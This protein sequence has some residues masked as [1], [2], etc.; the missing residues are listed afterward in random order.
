[1]AILFDNEARTY[2]ALLVV[3]YGGPEA[4]EEVMPFLDRVLAGRPVPEARKLEVA[5]HYLH[6]G[7]VSPIQQQT[8]D[9]IAALDADLRGAGLGLPIYWGNRNWH[10]LL[11]DTFHR[12][13]K[14][15]VRRALAF[16]TSAYSCWSGCRQYREDLARAVD[17]SGG[18]GISVDKIRVFYNHPGFIE[19]NAARLRDALG[20][21]PDG[22]RAAVLFSA[23]SIPLSMAAECRYEAQIAE[24][25]RLVAAACGVPAHRVVYQSRSGPPH[26]PWL[27]P[28]V[29]DVIRT[30]DPAD[31]PAVVVAPIG[32]LS[33]H[34][35]VVY[36]LDTEAR[37]AAR[38]RGLTFVRAGSA[39]TH[40]A[41]VAMIRDLI[42]ERL[43]AHPD[44][45]FLGACGPSHDICPARCCL[46]G[47][48][49]PPSPA[50][51]GNPA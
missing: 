9:L 1:M 7:G 43:T 37:D 24:T 27:E 25:A 20:Q 16:V 22:V 2:D 31:T 29:C 5:E 42:R 30:L 14:D 28:D 13:R 15:G 33:D 12:M 19:A 32:F 41:F 26:Q 50:L 11:P 36:D 49:T 17:E 3:S 18:P 40:P 45:T 48:L 6:F 23:H 8:R 47:G 21:L 44:R 51:C 34:M 4:P 39:G 38:E 46:S 35:E 10:P